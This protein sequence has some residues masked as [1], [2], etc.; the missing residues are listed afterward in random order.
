MKRVL[1]T[2]LFVLLAASF[3]RAEVFRVTGFAGLAYL[4]SRTVLGVQAGTSLILPLAVEGE[5]FRTASESSFPSATY[6]SAGVRVQPPLV[7][8]SPYFAAGIG[9]VRTRL[10]S[11]SSSHFTVNGGG[12]AEVNLAPFVAIQGE[13]RVFR[14]SGEPETTTFKRVSIGVSLKL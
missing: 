2:V 6:Y 3:A 13:F 14:I 12:G 9:L 5:V 11:G 10:D 4:E 8:F 1:I 7:Q